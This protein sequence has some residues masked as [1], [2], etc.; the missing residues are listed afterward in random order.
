VPTSVSSPLLRVD[1]LEAGYGK[2][3]VLHGVSL[4][5]QAGEI[6]AL[7]GP[8]GAGKTTLMRSISG[9]L[10]P[11]AG[12]VVLSAEKLKEYTP[13]ETG[14]LGL[15][16]V[17]EGHQV[18]KHLSVEQNLLLAAYDLPRRARIDRVE[19]ALSLFPEIEAKRAELGSALSGGQQ[20]ML[21]VAQGLVKRPKLLILDEPSA[22]LSPILVDRVF[23]VV[24]QLREHGA[25]V[26]LVEQIVEKAL[27]LADR[28]Y[29]MAQG[30][31]VIEGPAAQPG[32]AA[33]LEEAYL[34]AAA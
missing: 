26:I 14:R 31:I 20:Q 33:R 27:K 11:T 24:S 1:Q 25:A 10:R 4:Q 13:R 21:V 34:G 16:H 15:V 12:E 19:E 28:L 22:G 6:V 17:I 3:R 30:S 29:G 2:I 23:S 8:N 5:V 9:L 7:L 18:F 32:L